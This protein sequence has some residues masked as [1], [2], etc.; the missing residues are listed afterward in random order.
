MALDTRKKRIIA[1]V[2]F[3]AFVFITFPLLVWIF[4]PDIAGWGME[5][6]TTKPYAEKTLI[7]LGPRAI[8]QQMEYYLFDE[9]NEEC[10]LAEKDSDYR[11]KLLGYLGNPNDVTLDGITLI[12]FAS[13]QGYPN[14]VS[15]LIDMG[16]DFDKVDPWGKSPLAYAII[17][18]NTECV[19]ILLN[20][21]AN[22]KTKCKLVLRGADGPDTDTVG[23]YLHLLADTNYEEDYVTLNNMLELLQKTGLDINEK[24]PRG[25]SPLFYTYDEKTIEIFIQ[26]G[27]DINIRTNEGKTLLDYRISQRLSIFYIDFLRKH[28]AKTGAE[29]DAE[30]HPSPPAPESPPQQ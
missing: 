22:P 4:L 14:L 9:V 13:L 2:S 8:R 1:I 21:G 3:N 24:N 19:V 10:L 28:G 27:A 20:R 16:A 6:E 30:S 7:W 12:G 5:Y 29:L 17:S 25:E 11:K 18:R 26:H 23:T 15:D